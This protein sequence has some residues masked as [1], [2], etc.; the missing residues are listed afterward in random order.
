MSKPRKSSPPTLAESLPAAFAKLHEA[1][2]RLPHQ[3]IWN[4]ASGQQIVRGLRRELARLLKLPDRSEMD[5]LKLGL[6]QSQIDDIARHVKI[7]KQAIKRSHRILKQ[8]QALAAQVMSEPGHAYAYRRRRYR[9]L[10]AQDHDLQTLLWVLGVGLPPQDHNARAEAFRALEQRIGFAPPS[11]QEAAALRKHLTPGD[12]AAFHLSIQ[13]CCCVVCE[14]LR[15]GATPQDDILKASLTTC[16]C[17]VCFGLRK[18][19]ERAAPVLLAYG[20]RIGL[21]IAGF[22][23][24]LGAKTVN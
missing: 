24:L 16:P 11:G 9:R 8:A 23:S 17:G 20:R 3:R 2:R 5:R 14:V 7:A 13:T 22:L 21:P 10:L 6:L 19:T 12:A 4:L 1:Q 15:A 18:L